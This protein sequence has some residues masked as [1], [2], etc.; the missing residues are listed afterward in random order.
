MPTPKDK[1]Q[2]QQR[3]IN[4]ELHHP[5]ALRV[6]PPDA[7]ERIVYRPNQHQQGYD[8]HHA[9]DGGQPVCLIAE[10]V[11]IVEHHIRALRHNGLVDEGDERIRPA[12]EHGENRS[13]RDHYGQYGDECQQCRKRHARRC[14]RYALF[15]ETADDEPCKCTDFIVRQTL[16]T[17]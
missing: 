6:N 2:S 4:E 9:A 17:L 3:P 5:G 8:Q 10:C 7:V 11:D 1:G 12:V 13:D 14:L 16:P 15:T